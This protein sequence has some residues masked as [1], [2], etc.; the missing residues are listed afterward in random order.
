LF[1]S[2]LLLPLA[3][4]ASCAGSPPD[5]GT[6]AGFGDVEEREWYLSE[7]RSAGV[8]VRMDREKLDADGFEGIFSANFQ[9]GRLSGMG[10]PNRYFGP[11]TVDGNRGLDIG[12]LASTLM[13]AF[14]EPDGLTEHEYFG[15]LSRVTRWD[16]RE[17][18]LELYSTDEAG[19]EAVLIFVQG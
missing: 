3:L 19:N 16:L 5:R 13:L 15:Y 7:L 1:C 12:L 17:G 11:Y 9:E 14:R 18:K 4:L 2:A 10:A 6:G 8:S